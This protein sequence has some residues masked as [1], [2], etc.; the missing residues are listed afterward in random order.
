VITKS[1]A[2]ALLRT[3]V[4]VAVLSWVVSLPVAA[5]AASSAPSHGGS[6]PFALLVYGIG[7]FICHQRPE[8]SFHM[9]GVALPVCARCTGIYV[10]AAMMVLSSLLQVCRTRPSR[11][12]SRFPAN[13]MVLVLAVIPSAAT[14]AYEWSAGAPPANWIRAAAGLPIGL[15]LV[16]VMAR[17]RG[18]TPN[19]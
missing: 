6:Y 2:G 14:L 17:G 13:A 15:A 9:Y 19:T 11:A 8:R 10:G 3:A 7:S 4:G 18:V 1:L 12:R 5:K 16:G